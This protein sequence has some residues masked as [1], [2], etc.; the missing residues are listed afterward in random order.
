MGSLVLAYLPEQHAPAAVLALREMIESSTFDP[1]LPEHY[2]LFILDSGDD[3]SLPVA[4]A[5]FGLD[6]QAEMLMGW[7][8]RHERVHEWQLW[9]PDEPETVRVPG[10]EA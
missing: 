9:V 6:D 10:V 1:P 2:S 3:D 4:L 5:A 8:E 7:L